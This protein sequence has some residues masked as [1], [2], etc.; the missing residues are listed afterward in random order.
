M[1]L[2]GALLALGMACSAPPAESAS[3]ARGAQQATFASLTSVGS[4]TMTTT[5]TRTAQGS[6]RS[7]APSVE[8]S[9]IAWNGPDAWSWTRE[10]DR[11]PIAIHLV[12]DGRAW[13]GREA[14][15]QPAADPEPLR[16]A[17]ARGWDP[18]AALSFVR[19]QYALTR[20]ED[21]DAREV[22][23]RTAWRHTLTLPPTEEVAA[24]PEGT[25]TRPRRRPAW[26]LIRADGEAWLDEVTAVP[27]AATMTVEA[28]G[29]RD[30]VR[31]VQL[32]I[33]VEGIGKPATLPTPAPKDEPQAPTPPSP[34]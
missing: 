3:M 23:A 20:D 22:E 7:G 1:S 18:W 11:S 30:E 6:G 31:T 2:L 24:G 28:R 34:R 8:T 4:F 17:L 16:V 12:R 21:A 27:L 9:V 32:E 19:G 5:V 29:D 33:R 10:K 25:K 13:T 26:E 14:P 15:D